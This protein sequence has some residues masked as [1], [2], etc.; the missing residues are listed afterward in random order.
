MAGFRTSAARRRR[1]TLAVPTK[2]TSSDLIEAAAF[3]LIAQRCRRSYLHDLRGDLQSL[4]SS[5]ELMM[6]AG[7]ANPPNVALA[8]KA[9]GLARKALLGHER[10][11]SEVLESLAPGEETD[12]SVDLATLAAEVVKLLR[13]DASRGSVSLDARAGSAAM[14]KTRPRLCRGFAVG[15]SAMLIDALPPAAALILETELKDGLAI[16]AWRSDAQFPDL[17]IPAEF[18][19]GSP[20]TPFE[21]ILTAASRWLAAAGGR[22]DLPGSASG[23]SAVRILHPKGASP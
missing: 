23:A 18:D 7:R 10:A 4:N 3:T 14:I 11:L 15:I 21:L 17:H 2:L 5:L 22:L 6:R 16:L 8:D 1:E 19:A 20:L 12:A 9:G 13:S